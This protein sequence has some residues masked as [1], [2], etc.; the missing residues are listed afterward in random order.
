MVDPPWG[1]L[2]GWALKLDV[3]TPYAV[4]V[5]GGPA[6]EEELQV[7]VAAAEPSRLVAAAVAADPRLQSQAL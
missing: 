2:V 4:A 1:S 3:D 5:V 7:A 6:V